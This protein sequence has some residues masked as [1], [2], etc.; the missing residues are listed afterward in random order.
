LT[1]L[2]V[3]LQAGDAVLVLLASANRDPAAQADAE[4]FV[5]ERRDRRDFGFGAGA[6]ACP[7]E[8]IAQ[9][10]ARAAVA[11]AA[12]DPARLPAW[13]FRG[14]YRPLVNVRIPVFD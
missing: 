3:P 5:V 13:R 12:A 6:H 11:H 8:R 4:A 14:A 9:A 7:G 1:V 10:I 2:G